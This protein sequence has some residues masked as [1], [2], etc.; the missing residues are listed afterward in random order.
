[1]MW[2]VDQSGGYSFSDATDP[3]QETLFTLEP[4]WD[5]MFGILLARFGGSEQPWPVVEE[6]IRRT[7]F[8]IMRNT[9]KAESARKD[10]RFH[11]DNPEGVRKGKLDAGTTIRFPNH[12]AGG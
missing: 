4:N 8:R 1:A 11:I 3:N 7:P 2:K 10:S 12:A 9:L 5:Q 6:A